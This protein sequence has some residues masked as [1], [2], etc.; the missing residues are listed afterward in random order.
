[1][2]GAAIART[3]RQLQ[4]ASPARMPG[5]ADRTLA[6]SSAPLPCPATR[7]PSRYRLVADCAVPVNLSP[8]RRVLHLTQCPQRPQ[9][10]KDEPRPMITT[11]RRAPVDDAGDPA[12]PACPDGRLLALR[13]L[14]IP[15]VATRAAMSRRRTLLR[16]LAAFCARIQPRNTAELASLVL[17]MGEEID[18]RERMLD[19]ALR[20]VVTVPGERIPGS[21]AASRPARAGQ[22][23]QI[24]K[25]ATVGPPAQRERPRHGRVAGSRAEP[26]DIAD[27]QPTRTPRP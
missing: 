12:G 18:R 2:A 25:P 4:H 9:T 16:S 8:A 14:G 11:K 27:A 23:E 6:S 22:P 19:A 3:K 1:M 20:A 21:P 7:S 15:Q 5:R 17:H 24:C 26:A 10:A 13:C